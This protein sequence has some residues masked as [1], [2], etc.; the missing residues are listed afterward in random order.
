MNKDAMIAFAITRDPF[1]CDFRLGNVGK[2]VEVVGGY[3]L[4]FLIE[5]YQF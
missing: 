1:F 2:L 4:N 3:I 5:F